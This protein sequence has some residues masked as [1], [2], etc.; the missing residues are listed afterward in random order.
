MSFRTWY[1]SQKQT[2]KFHPGWIV[3]AVSGV[4]VVAGIIAIPATLVAETAPPPAAAASTPGA[5]G[6]GKAPG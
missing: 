4:L 6:H 3:M 5:S 2:R 1:E